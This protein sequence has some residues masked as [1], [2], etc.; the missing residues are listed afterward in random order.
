M[1]YT[2]KGSTPGYDAKTAADYLLSFSSEW[3]LLKEH[4]TSTFSGDI[5][6]S[7]GYFPFYIVTN[8]DGR[9]DQLAGLSSDCGVSASTLYYGLL[10]GTR[11]YYLFRLSL[12]ENYTA[13]NIETSTVKT[14]EN[15]GYVFKMTK[16][17]KDFSSSDMRDFALHSNTKSPMVHKVVEQAMEIGPSSWIA[18][19]S[20]GLDYIP[21]VFAFLKPGANSNGFP[22]DRYMMLAPS[23]G[24]Q[25][26]FYNVDGSNVHIDATG[27]IFNQG[28]P[29][30][31][32]VVLKDPLIKEAVNITYP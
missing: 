30:V 32:V 7:L 13:P 16:L 8:S 18:T 25:P 19:I 1:A 20:H 2:I 4:E 12:T 22:T 17:G 24:A 14:A 9:V 15:D 27:E 23:I 26:A 5:G 28:V 10:T 11:R 21:T 29:R 31:S 6:H 3:P